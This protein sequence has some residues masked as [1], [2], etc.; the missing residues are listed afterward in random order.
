MIRRSSNGTVT[1]DTPEDVAAYLAAQVTLGI[2]AA[3]HEGHDRETV[4]AFM[5]S[6]PVLNLIRDTYAARCQAGL[7]RVKSIQWI[8]MRLAAHYCNRHGI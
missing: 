4:G 3:G 8:G 6:D 7:D 1:L 2:A 5:T